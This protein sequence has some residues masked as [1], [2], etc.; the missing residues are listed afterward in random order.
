MKGMVFDYNKGITK[1]NVNKY[2]ERTLESGYS[3]FN[4]KVLLMA[5]SY[6]FTENGRTYSFQEIEGW[7]QEAGF[8]DLTRMDLKLPRSISVLIGRK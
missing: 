2:R 3:F 5:A 8:C 7:L 1:S 6:V 4:S